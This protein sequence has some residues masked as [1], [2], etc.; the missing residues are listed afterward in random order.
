MNSLTSLP[1]PL[2]PSVARQVQKF[3][4]LTLSPYLGLAHPIFGSNNGAHS[5][6]TLP[7]GIE[8]FLQPSQ[9]YPGSTTS[10]FLGNVL[11]RSLVSGLATQ[12][13]LLILL[14][15]H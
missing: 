8:I 6:L 3:H 2:P 14:N 4:G 11:Y 7:P 12:D 13:F 10:I 1:I 15:C 5:L 9:H